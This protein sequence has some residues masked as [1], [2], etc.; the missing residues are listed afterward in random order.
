MLEKGLPVGKIVGVHGIKG[1]LKVYSYAES[2]SLFKSDDPI[3]IDGKDGRRT[4][5][6]IEWAKPHKHV[7][8]LSLKD[9]TSV[10]LAR[11]LIGAELFVDQSLLP[12]LDE[13]SHYWVDIIGLSVYAMDRTYLGCVEAII[14]TSGNDV[15]VVKH[16]GE[17]IL[18]PA[19]ESVVLDID[20]KNKTM[21]VDLPEGLE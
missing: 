8:L 7:V 3:Y 12:E 19:L 4:I 15:F 6:T 20:I 10:D 1:N 11:D 5:Y 9:V 18:I 14:P 16:R 2:P 17:E 13:G 21:R